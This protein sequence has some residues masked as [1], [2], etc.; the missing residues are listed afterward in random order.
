MKKILQ[1]ISFLILVTILN[2][3]SV[4]ES[5][6]F[7]YAKWSFSGLVVDASTGQGLNKAEVHYVIA[8]ETQKV[9]TDSLGRFYIDELPY[10]ST[11]FSFYHQKVKGKD[12]LQYAPQVVLTGSLNESSA[13]EGVVASNAMVIRLKPLNA[14]LRAEFFIELEETAIKVPLKAANAWIT[15]SD[16][17]YINLLPTTFEAKT[18]SAGT[19]LFKNLPAQTPLNLHLAPIDY[20]GQRYVWDPIPL[21]NLLS[22]KTTDLGRFYL[23][24]DTLVN[25][26]NLLR[27]SNVLDKNFIG[28]KNISPLEIPYFVFKIALKATPFICNSRKL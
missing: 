26:K 24:A 9:R 22:A 28:L 14:T 20:Q 6:G 1:I 18:D 27:A 2:S 12:T 11:A 25:D 5:T 19:V 15:N 17:T 13:M 8:G 10:G 21:A 7:E 4:S 16:S 23:S 3:C